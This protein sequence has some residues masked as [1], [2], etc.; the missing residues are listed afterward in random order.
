M[1]P[2]GELPRH[3]GAQDQLGRPD[4][5]RV[6]E[7]LDRF[8]V[9][10]VSR[11]HIQHRIGI[12]LHQLPHHRLDLARAQRGLI[13]LFDTDPAVGE[14]AGD[15]NADGIIEGIVERTDR[16]VRNAHVIDPVRALPT[17]EIGEVGNRARP[18]RLVAGIAR[19]AAD[20][21][22]L[23]ADE[24]Q[25][26]QLIGEYR[27][28]FFVFGETQKQAVRPPR[29]AAHRGDHMLVQSLLDRPSLADRLLV[30][31]PHDRP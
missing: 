6:T 12:G 22:V 29:I 26:L 13:G 27:T 9:L 17:D 30:L 28:N 11:Q 21:R 25:I 18:D 24:S 7:A 15:P 8:S 16:H 31:V 20:H 14:F 4:L 2:V 10:Q 19:L 3:R 1:L 5:D 23:K